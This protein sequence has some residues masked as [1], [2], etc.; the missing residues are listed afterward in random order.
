MFSPLE[1]IVYSDPVRRNGNNLGSERR[2]YTAVQA[3]T[4]INHAAKNHASRLKP[5][6]Y[7]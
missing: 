5:D 3:A 6:P 2:I 4:I 7:Y 1:Y